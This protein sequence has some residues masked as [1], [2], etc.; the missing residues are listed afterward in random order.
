MPDEAGNTCPTCGAPI[1]MDFLCQNPTGVTGAP[2]PLR[3]WNPWNPPPAPGPEYLGQPPVLD[4]EEW[5]TESTRTVSASE[6]FTC[7]SIGYNGY[8][9]LLLVNNDSR[10]VVV[11]D[12]QV[13]KLLGLAMLKHPIYSWRDVR[14]V[15]K[16]LRLAEERGHSDA[17]KAWLTDLAHRLVRYLPPEAS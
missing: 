7:V 5:G 12:E 6:G 3:K 4:A 8:G 10:A 16:L 1:T 11:S 17:E 13:G 15:L 2:A 9:S 14:G